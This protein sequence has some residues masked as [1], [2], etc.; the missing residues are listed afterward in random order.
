MHLQI[1]YRKDLEKSTKSLPLDVKESKA[2]LIRQTSI[3]RKQILSG[4]ASITQFNI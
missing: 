4:D 3:L 1:Y 2:Q